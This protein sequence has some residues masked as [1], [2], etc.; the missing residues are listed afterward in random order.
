MAKDNLIFKLDNLEYQY[1]YLKDTL[2]E[3]EPRLNSTKKLYN[4]KGKKNSKKVAKLLNEIKINE[5]EKQLYELRVEIFNNKAHHLEKNLQAFL[6]KQINQEG[7]SINSSKSSIKKDKKSYDDI[8]KLIKEKYGFENF[9]D[10]IV[11]SKVIKLSVSKIFPN[12]HFLSSQNTQWFQNHEFWK[13]NN[14]K[15]HNYNPSRIWNDVIM[16]IKRSDQLVSTL[17]NNIKCKEFFQR[18]DNGMDVFLAINKEKKIQEKKE[19]KASERKSKLERAAHNDRESEDHGE[20]SSQED[21]T[22]DEDAEIGDIDENLDENDMEEILK[23]YEGILAASDNESTEEG[24]SLDSSVNYNQITDEEPSEDE[25]D[26][27]NEQPKQKKPKIQLP[28][29]MGG[30]ISGGSE[31]E[32]EEDEVAREQKDNTIQRKNRRGQRARRKIWEKKYG[33]E[34]KHVQREIET[35]VAEKKQ[36]QTDYEARVAKR[37]ARAAELAGSGSNLVAVGERKTSKPTVEPK[38]PNEDHPS[39]VAKKIAEEKQKNAKFAGKKIIF[40]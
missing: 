40:D 16:G 13:I 12:K 15:V 19:E 18:F 11:K 7:K 22:S 30:Y 10:L 3:F 4:S 8:L 6:L 33:K 29:L 28:E 39:W 1:H 5:V 24:F 2:N 31:S 26:G 36:R 14:E 37:E 38:T 20:I 35:H 25:S 21:E 9:V 27:E 32:F 23:Q 34:A 17:M